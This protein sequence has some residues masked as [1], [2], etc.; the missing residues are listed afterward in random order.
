MSVKHKINL[1]WP[2]HT[3][4]TM[5]YIVILLDYLTINYDAVDIHYWLLIS[6]L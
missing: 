6:L 2:K 4:C 5:H 1:V 3:Q